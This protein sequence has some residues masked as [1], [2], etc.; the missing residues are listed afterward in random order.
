LLFIDPRKDR[1]RS[2]IDASSIFTPTVQEEQHDDGFRGTRVF[3]RVAQVG[4]RVHV[5]EQTCDIQRFLHHITDFYYMLAAFFVCLLHDT[6]LSRFKLGVMNSEL[7][8]AL[9][10]HHDLLGLTVIW[11]ISDL[12]G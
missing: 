3:V 12:C 1:P 4:S 10:W 9:C 7:P 8:F 11:R 6:I 5:C 2:G